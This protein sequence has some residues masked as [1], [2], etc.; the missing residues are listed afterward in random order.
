MVAIVGVAL[1]ATA[2]KSPAGG[3]ALA[4]VFGGQLPRLELPQLGSSPPAGG[5]AVG[6]IPGRYRALYQQA[7]RDYRLPWQVLAGIGKVES[8]HGRS[9]LPGVR[10]GSNAAGACGP[11]QIG[12]VPG[13]RAGNSWARYGRGS[14]YAPADAIPAA[15][16]Y[17]NGH[18]A[19]RNLDRAIWG[20]NHAGWYVAKVKGWA[21]R[22]GW[23]G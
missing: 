19:Q 2:A 1:L 22:Y 8:N 20:Y 7:G 16:R 5:P 4:D 17:L 3:V 11:M 12:C 9:R 18:G 10:S 14:V 15:A 13:S 21:R 6:G 23:R